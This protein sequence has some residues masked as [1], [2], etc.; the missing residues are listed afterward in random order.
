MNEEDRINA[1][2]LFYAEAP[3][4]V[5]KKSRAH[6]LNIEY[7]MTFEFD[8][9]KKKEI[10]SSILGELGEGGVLQEPIFF[11]YGVHTKIGRN[12]F[13]NFNFVVQDDAEVTI[14]DNC[15]FGPNVTVVTFVHPLLPEERRELETAVGERKDLCYAKPVHIGSDCWFGASVT[16][17]PGVTIGDGCAIGAG[18]VVTRDIHPR[19]FAAGAQCRVVRELTDADSMRNKPYILAD[20]RVID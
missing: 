19:T 14:G 10:I 15:M 8:V 7:N 6:R 13:A 17:Y 3:E 11:H 2:I 16:V 12:F 4:L 20:N 18:A 5:E 1:G 9:E